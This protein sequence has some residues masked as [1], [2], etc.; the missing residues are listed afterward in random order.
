MD[1]ALYHS[2]LLAAGLMLSFPQLPEGISANSSQLSPSP[3]LGLGG[4]SQLA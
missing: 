2:Y 4:E 1:A 3:G